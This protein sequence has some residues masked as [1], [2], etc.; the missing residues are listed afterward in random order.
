MGHKYRW[1]VKINWTAMKSGN[2]ADK[3]HSNHHVS[4]RD[5]RRSI[6]LLHTIVK[7]R[8]RSDEHELTKTNYEGRSENKGIFLNLHRIDPTFDATTDSAFCEETNVSRKTEVVLTST[9]D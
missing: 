1:R 5:S 3:S 4:T 8:K 9:T 7:G 6:M 2:H